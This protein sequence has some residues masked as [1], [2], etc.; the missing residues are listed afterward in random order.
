VETGNEKLTG[1][2]SSMVYGGQSFPWG[3]IKILDLGLARFDETLNGDSDDPLTMAGQGG[4]RGSADYLAP[5]QALDFHT[6][7]IRADIYALG[8][9][10][11]YLLTGKPPFDGGSLAQKLMK[12]QRAAP[13]PLEKGRAG[14]PR[15]LSAIIARMMAKKPQDRFQRPAEVAAAI[16]SVSQRSWI[17]LWR[18]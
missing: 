5:E 9:T 4:I 13:P 2:S 16:A 8:C 17:N 18:Q 10:F 7:D 12:H 3:L 6:A 15:K 1:S 11:F 14:L